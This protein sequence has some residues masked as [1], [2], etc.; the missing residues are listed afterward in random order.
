MNASYLTHGLTIAVI[1]GLICYMW[2]SVNNRLNAIEL[3]L[4]FDSEKRR[5][6]RKN[7]ES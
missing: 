2:K 5:D 1:G 7:S 4:V 6:S 3:R